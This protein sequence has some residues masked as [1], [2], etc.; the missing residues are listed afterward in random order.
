M[1]DCA[2]ETEEGICLE[3]MPL[4]GLQVVM[5]REMWN[6]GVISQKQQILNKEI[7]HSMWKPIKEKKKD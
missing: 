1:T 7:K 6:Q 2:Q 3:K 5:G 4:Y